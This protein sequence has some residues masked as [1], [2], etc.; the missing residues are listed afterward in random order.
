MGLSCHDLLVDLESWFDLHHGQFAALSQHFEPIAK[1]VKRPALVDR[2]PQTANEHFTSVRAMA[3]GSRLLSVRL[4]FLEP[5]NYV[6]R[7][8]RPSSIVSASI[9]IGIE[10]TVVCKMLADGVF[11]VDFGV[12]GHLES[13][14]DPYRICLL[15]QHG[16]TQVCG[17]S[18]LG[19]RLELPR[20]VA[21]AP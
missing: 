10:P 18:Y 2:V 16:A 5:G 4:R 7:K 19:L 8:Q 17:W 13:P 21:G 3:L 6:V 15:I 11:E 1:D 14:G 12:D 20:F 9:A